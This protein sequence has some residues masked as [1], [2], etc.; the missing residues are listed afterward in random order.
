MSSFQVEAEKSDASDPAAIHQISEFN[1]ELIIR[2]K[3]TCAQCTVERP[4]ITPRFMQ[5]DSTL[6]VFE[7]DGPVQMFE[8]RSAVLDNCD[9]P[10]SKD[11]GC[12][13]F[14]L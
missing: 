10:V 5:Y 3:M 8:M 4:C 1:T 13:V 6:G 9:A 12:C 2:L 14:C 11:D 7:V